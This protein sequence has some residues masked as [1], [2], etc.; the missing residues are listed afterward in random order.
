MRPKRST[1]HPDTLS[2]ARAETPP[3][4]EIRRNPVREVSD[5][6]QTV[7]ANGMPVVEIPISGRLATTIVIAFPAGALYEHEDEIGV[8]HMLEHVAFKGAAKYR[9]ARD[10]NRAAGYLG[11]ELEGATTNGYV[12]FSAVVRAESAMDTIDLLSDVSGRALLERPYLEAERAVIFKEI[13]EVKDDPTINA[14]EQL[15]AALFDGHRLATGIAGDSTHVQGITYDQIVS[16]RERHWSPEGGV[17]VLAGNL[18][19]LDRAQL[20]DLLLRI[21][22]RNPPPH[23]PPIGPFVRRIKLDEYDGDVVDFRLAYAVSGLDLT[24]RQD[25]AVAAV[26]SNLV[27]GPVGSR[28]FDELREQRSLCYEID[29][30]LWGHESS[31]FLSVECSVHPSDLAE[32]YERIDAI[33]RSLSESG[34]T[35]EETL[36]ARSYTI[37]STTLDF[38]SVNARTDYA[39]GLIMD[40]KDHNVDSLQYLATL[41]SVTHED[42]VSLAANVQP[43]PCVGC[44][45]PASAAEFR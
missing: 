36:R 39:V 44:A 6:T 11:T 16:F 43:G 27:G 10:L 20:T 18:E 7:L 4:T 9:T 26:Y 1:E 13:A 33:V 23:P 21:P 19:H 31:S 45:G 41:E 5:I 15:N 34:P 42:L 40:Y 37:G 8:A 12:E 17:M 29:G 24:R 22:H 28:L 35:E 25:R 14:E 38:E 2:S 3:D 32:T 30:F